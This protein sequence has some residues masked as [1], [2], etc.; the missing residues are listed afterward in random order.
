LTIIAE[1]FPTEHVS[2]DGVC[3]ILEAA[4]LKRRVIGRKHGLVVIAE[5]IAEKLDP[6]ELAGIPGVEV[7]HDPYGHIILGD[8]PLATILKRNIQKRFAARGERIPI[9]D[10]TLGYELRCAPPI[11]FDIDY[12][13]TLGHGAVRFLLAEPADENLRYGGL[14]CWTKDVCTLCLSKISAIQPRDAPVFAWLTSSPNT[15]RWRATTCSDWS[16]PIWRTP[17]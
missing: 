13:R 4:I 14:V 5:G 11:P 3:G 12:T 1:E 16:G 6:E 10:V 7:G 8:I 15:T 2:L 9:V 17:T